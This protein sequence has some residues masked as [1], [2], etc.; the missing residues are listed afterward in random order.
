[1]S[2]RCMVITAAMIVSIL[3]VGCGGTEST[4]T[5]A[6]VLP[7]AAYTPTFTPVPPTATYTPVPPTATP[8]PVLPT[9]TPT[10]KPNTGSIHGQ[11]RFECNGQPVNIR[12]YAV[13]FRSGASFSSTHTEVDENGEF[14]FYNLEPGSYSVHKS[15]SLN[16]TFTQ[17]GE[18]AGVWAGKTTNVIL[19]SIY[20]PE[21]KLV[22][23]VDDAVVT[24][25]KLTF[26]W[27]PY[28]PG[29]QY[30][31]RISGDLD[32]IPGGSSGLT[33]GATTDTTS[34][35]TGVLASGEFTWKVCI[36]KN[37]GPRYAICSLEES[38]R[39]DLP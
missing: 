6:P 34:E 15:T 28:R 27:E 24:A 26:E 18:P 38:F 12:Y 16:V 20:C 33:L 32:G 35:V 22:S 5:P 7:T 2:T 9:P 37:S 25:P 8:T 11:I 30:Q 36:L 4:T 23:P 17:E 29:S 1:M 14:S 31:V 3:M 39:V 19:Y 21:I 13:L 10:P